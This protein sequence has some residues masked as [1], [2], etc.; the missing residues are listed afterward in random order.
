MILWVRDRF[1]NLSLYHYRM[2]IVTIF[3][4]VILT[5]AVTYFAVDCLV[6]RAIIDVG[7]VLVWGLF[8][9]IVVALMVERDMAEARRLVSQQTDPLVEQVHRV[10]EEH[11]DLIT[12]VRRQV[13]DLECRTRSAFGRLGVDLPTKSVSL[14]G[15]VTFGALTG[16]ATLRVSGGN[17]WARLRRR[18]RS[19]MRR[20]REIVYGNP[21]R[22]SPSG[23]L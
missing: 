13:E 20:I 16:S 3:V 12:D 10:E 15:R 5:V 9:V 14:R 2:I 17:K 8:V 7:V 4:P 21:E 6:V 1:K 22:G 19:A 18:F 23:P 11:R